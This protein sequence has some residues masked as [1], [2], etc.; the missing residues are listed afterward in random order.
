MMTRHL[1]RPAAV[2]VSSIMLTAPAAAQFLALRKTPAAR[3]P[4]TLA[5]SYHV[6]L[7]SAWPQLPAAEGCENGGSETVEGTLTRTASG[8]Y[9]GTF[10]RRTHLLFCGAHGVDGEAC[11][12]VL[13]GEGQVAVHG[14]IVADEWS[15]SGQALRAVWTPA[16]EHAAE[17]RGA[18]G[19]GFKQRV[20]RMYLTARHGAEFA[21]P[22]AGAAPRTER[23]EDY[24][25]I[26]DVE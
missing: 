1:H 22:R 9:T 15:P 13:Y 10:T 23:L 12:L 11:E 14:M 25:W 24:A 3:L 6:R 16:A 8:D 17:V 2:L 7:R 5:A 19:A 20:Q 26:V 18:C 21:L 4:A